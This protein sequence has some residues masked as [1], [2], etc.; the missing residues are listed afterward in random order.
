MNWADIGHHPRWLDRRN[1]TL[2]S[3]ALVVY[4][5]GGED[6]AS[7]LMMYF[8]RYSTLD[9][10]LQEKYH[11]LNFLPAYHELVRAYSSFAASK[12]AVHRSGYSSAD[13]GASGG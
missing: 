6:E 9:T 11:Q 5:D 2:P 7:G 12:D 4:T 1:L 8:P 13:G 3:K 10:Q